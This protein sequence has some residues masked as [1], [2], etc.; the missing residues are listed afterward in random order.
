MH[1]QQWNELDEKTLLPGFHG[2]FVH[3]DRVTVANWRVDAGAS[4]PEHAHPHEQITMLIEGVFEMTING[5]THRLEAGAV[6]TIPGGVPH[7]GRAITDCR[8]TDVFQ[9]AREDYR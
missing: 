7:A 6:V 4:L 9:P 1:V 8:I 5:E 3:T 2:R